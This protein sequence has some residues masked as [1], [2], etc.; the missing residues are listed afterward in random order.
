MYTLSNFVYLEKYRKDAYGILSFI[1]LA[2]SKY[3]LD[4]IS[5]WL[6]ILEPVLSFLVEGELSHDNKV[7]LELI[8]LIP[9]EG[10]LEEDPLAVKLLN[11]R[12][13]IL[14]AFG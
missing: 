14:L 11:N 2:D 10:S 3:I 8:S 12:L 13:Y 7:T 1:W 6:C 4:P 5:D 9:L